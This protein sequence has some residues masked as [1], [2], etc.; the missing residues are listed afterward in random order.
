MTFLFSIRRAALF[1]VVV[2]LST[3]ACAQTLWQGTTY[4]MSVEQVKAAV[5]R[6][7]APAEPNQLYGGAEE[8]L[9]LAG[10]ELQ[11]KDFLA[12]FYFKDGSLVQVTLSMINK[13]QFNVAM[14]VVEGLI[15]TLRA[16]YGKELS[17]GVKTSE[18]L[19]KADYKW[20]SGRT[21]IVLVCLAVGDNPAT[22][23]I[24]YQARIAREA[25]KL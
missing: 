17:G 3:A 20:L 15:T 11:N 13:Q 21:N 5:P 12:S 2:L 25:D 14:L 6:A 18:F 23:N 22:V 10:V 7:T 8:L 4:G 9:R 24:V 16:K 1:I 19:K